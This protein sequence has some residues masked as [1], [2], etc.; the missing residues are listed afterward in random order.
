MSR[1]SDHGLDAVA[2]Q[3]EDAARAN[4][5]R[6][7]EVRGWSQSELARRLGDAGIPGIHQTTIARIE[8]GT[9]PI[10]LAEAVALARIFELRVDDLV[11]SD[12]ASA[13]RTALAYL[14]DLPP[15]VGRALDELQYGR[16]ELARALDA[17][18]VDDPSGVSVSEE[19]DGG[20]SVHL[21]ELAVETLA[22]TR[23]DRLAADAMRTLT[24]QLG[25]E[26]L[27]GPH[28]IALARESSE[29]S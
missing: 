24:A 14:S 4:L 8:A 16:F 11:E 18:D 27:D 10:R 9:R 12:D 1:Q 17:L 25:D 28:T 21:F 29:D 23:P 2:D 13:V 20:W 7:R 3:I 19:V 6:M 5:L 26:R 22:D 15:R